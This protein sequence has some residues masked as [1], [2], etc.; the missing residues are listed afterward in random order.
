MAVRERPVAVGMRRGEELTRTIGREIRTQRLRAGLSQARLGHAVGLSAVEIGRIERG[1]APWLSL[2]NASAI[3]GA[4]GLRLWAKVYPAGPPLRDAGQLR[5]LEEFEARIH[6]DVPRQREWPIPGD[7]AGR[8]LD[9]LLTVGGAR[10]GVEAETVL[11]DLQELERELN[12]KRRGGGLHRVILLAK[13]SQRNRDI[14]RGADA[15]RRAYP[16]ST[17]AVMTALAAGRDPG[18]DGIVV[19]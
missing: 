3:L 18:G 14:I 11:V 9:L 6:P 15:L 1:A 17:R 12:L 4:L 19:L 16:L 2:V 13:G 10:V 8:A 7:D 5:L